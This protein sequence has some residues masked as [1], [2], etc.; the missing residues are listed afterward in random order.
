MAS[1]GS[2]GDYRNLQRKRGRRG[3]VTMEVI[4]NREMLLMVKEC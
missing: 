3:N 2:G 1:D 4:E